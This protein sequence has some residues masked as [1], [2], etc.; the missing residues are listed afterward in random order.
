MSYIDAIGYFASA[1]TMFASLPQLV[2]ITQTHSAEDVS[3]WMFILYTAGSVSWFAYG[4]GK[5]AMP[6]VL[7]SVVTFSVGVA[8]IFLKVKFTKSIRSGKRVKEAVT[9]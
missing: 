1:I 2:K 8:I 4:L 6:I 3:L 5:N 9:S 7:T